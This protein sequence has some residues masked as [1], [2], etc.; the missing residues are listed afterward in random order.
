[1]K[2]IWQYLKILLVLA[3]L[4][5][6]LNIWE[7]FYLGVL[8]FCLYFLFLVPYWQTVWRRV[9]SI[10]NETW[11]SRV[12]GVFVLFSLIG[13]VAGMF[14]IFYK[15]TSLTLWLSY[16]LVAGISLLLVYFFKKRVKDISVEDDE[17][18]ILFKKNFSAR[19]FT[20]IYLI[21][22]AIAFYLLLGARSSAVLQTPWQTLSVYYLPIFFVLSSLSGLFLFFR[23]KNKT[24]LFFLI[25][26]TLLLHLY[27]PLTHENPWGGDVWRH[28]AME[29]RIVQGETIE[30][31]LSVSK[32]SYSHLWGSTILL[33][34][35]FSQDLLAVNKW[36]M[37]L[38]WSLFAPFLFYRIGLLLFN[39]HR[40]GMWLA[41]LALLPFSLQALPAL[42]LPVSWDFLLFLLVFMLWLQ[43]FRE[44]YRS[45]KYLAWFFSFFLIFGYALY[46]I[47]TALIILFGY[48]FKY[49]ENKIIRLV[50]LFSSI[51][52]LPVIEFFGKT[53]YWPEKI[54]W[55]DNLKQFIGQFTGWFFASAIRPHDILSGNLFFN[56]TP[57]YA[58]V[59]SIFSDWRWLVIPIMI[60]FILSIKYGVLSTI[61]K[62]ENLQWSVLAGLVFTIF[63][64]YFIGWYVLT[65]ERL[66][67][68]RLD[69]VLV[70]VWLL[71]IIFAFDKVFEKISFKKTFSKIFVLLVVLVLSWLG[72]LTYASGPDI[73]VVSSGEFE[74]AEYIWTTDYRLTL[75]LSSGRRQTMDEKHVCVLMDTWVLL[76][77]ETLSKG[78]IVGGGFPIDYN[79]AQPERVALL[80]AFEQDPNEEIINQAK[81]ITGAEY[82]W[83]MSD[84][85][86]KKVGE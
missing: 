76:P 13:S 53:S 35:T 18:V 77:L 14:I 75:G 9:L 20:I 21:F 57:D 38:A 1:M 73:R 41:W 42:S 78:E 47:L 31:V 80:E 27:L 67:T 4:Y 64:G 37:P 48:S 8:F 68:R 11:T 33:S 66:L 29:E 43:Y 10:A 82:C 84:D 49:F 60:I 61:F 32:F 7:N 25:L 81:E 17:E 83:M 50:I 24:V 71:F 36:F 45:Q 15:L 46:A 12:L 39:S 62:K 6:Q 74:T 5:C 55:L 2:K 28:V 22:W 52:I 3:L 30:P 56:H 69:M 70:F 16:V 54:N 23:F 44:H 59:S 26:Q 19:V 63:G 58:F 72:T 86:L 65:G 51:F 85:G 34:Q 79:F 40:R